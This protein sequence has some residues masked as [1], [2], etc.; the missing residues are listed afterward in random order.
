MPQSAEQTQSHKTPLLGVDFP[1][2]VRD[3]WQSGFWVLTAAY[4][5]FLSG[6]VFT[7][8][9]GPWQTEKDGHG[10]YIMIVVLAFLAIRYKDLAALPTKSEPV[11]GWLLII[12]GLFSFLLGRSQS[13]ILFEMGAHLPLLA[14]LVLLARS[15]AGLKLV[16]FPI[17][18]LGFAVPLPGWLLDGTTQWAKLAVSDMITIFLHDVGYPIAHDGVMILVDRH[19]LLVED[20]CAGLN[21]LY[22]LAAVG[23]L[24]IY[25]TRQDS[26]LRNLLLIGWIIPAA[27]LSNLVRVMLLVLI[28]YHLGEEAGQGFLHDFAGIIMFLVALGSF[29]LVDFA[30][31]AILSK[32]WQQSKGHSS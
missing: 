11:W 27:F 26:I 23:V 16:W 32:K 14:G 21:S 17:L 7:L 9:S 30:L 19:K 12:G 3:I 29:F 1:G 5:F 2:L 8:A 13:Q 10:L 15:W 28:T 22:S 20:A 4:L 25:L 6:T 24:Y 31:T 18:F